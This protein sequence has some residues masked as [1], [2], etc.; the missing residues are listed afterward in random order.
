[1]QFCWIQKFVKNGAL[2]LIYKNLAGSQVNES[3]DISSMARPNWHLFP[4]D[5]YL[6][7]QPVLNKFVAGRRTVQ[8][9]N[10][11]NCE[12]ICILSLLIWHKFA[13]QH[14]FIFNLDRGYYFPLGTS[15][16]FVQLNPCTEYS[17]TVPWT[18]CASD[19]DILFFNRTFLWQELSVDKDSSILNCKVI[20]DT[21]NKKLVRSLNIH[22][23]LH[24]G[25]LQFI[26]YHRWK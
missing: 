4:V 22:K 18:W 23:H 2:V 15:A 13:L 12:C 7:G 3:S 11:W 19:C 10:G 26:H 6:G 9:T 1:M 8:L 20:A 17:R 16:L 24:R 25:T 14:T 5:L 21:S